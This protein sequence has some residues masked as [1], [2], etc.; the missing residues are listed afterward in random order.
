MAAKELF[1]NKLQEF[2]ADL[3]TA[4]PDIPDLSLYKSALR[5]AVSFSPDQPQRL[6]RQLVSMP[7]KQHILDRDEAFFLE[8]DFDTCLKQSRDAV[9]GVV[10]LDIISK[11]R[12]VWHHMGAQDKENVWQYLKLLVMIDERCQ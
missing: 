7:F 9:P 4:Y 8:Y 1:N 11:I 10:D 6:F 12:S 5:L 3:A 2:V